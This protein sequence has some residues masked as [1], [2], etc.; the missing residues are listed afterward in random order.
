MDLVMMGWFEDGW[1][2]GWMDGWIRIWLIWYLDDEW[3]D[4]LIEDGWLDEQIHFPEPVPSCVF[5]VLL[6]CATADGGWCSVTLCNSLGWV[7]D[8]WCCQKKTKQRKKIITLLE[9]LANAGRRGRG[10]RSRLPRWHR[11]SGW[12]CLFQNLE[13]P[14]VLKERACSKP[15]DSFVRRCSTCSEKRYRLRGGVVKS[16]QRVCAPKKKKKRKNPAPVGQ[17]KNVSSWRR[18]LRTDT[19]AVV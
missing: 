18:A 4:K 19:H 15:A 8:L 12:S 2:D 9:E 3:M 11:G 14:H 6:F 10:Q 1:L 16:T 17:N 13:S 5:F 7:S